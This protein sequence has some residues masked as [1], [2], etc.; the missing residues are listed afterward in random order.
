[1]HGYQS[2]AAIANA[3]E[4]HQPFGP[5]QN[6]RQNTVRM[7]IT[8]TAGVLWPPLLFHPTDSGQ[9]A[10]FELFGG[11]PIDVLSMHFSICR[12]VVWDRFRDCLYSSAADGMLLSWRFAPPQQPSDSGDVVGEHSRKSEAAQ[13]LQD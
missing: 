3:E 8:P 1:M 5:V 2:S 12:A 9:L 6:L 11:Q 13:W 4:G 10:I 7:A